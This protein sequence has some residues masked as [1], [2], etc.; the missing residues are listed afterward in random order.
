MSS[1]FSLLELLITLTI[2][3]ILTAIAYP[4]YTQHIIKT[5]R[6]DAKTS[7]YQLATNLEIY[8]AEHNT[9]SG[10]P[11]DNN[12]SSQRFYQLTVLTTD[13]NSYSL[14]ASPVGPQQADKECGSFLLSHTGEKSNSELNQNQHCW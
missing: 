12:L 8:Y 13:E 4:Q 9:Y 3:S 1:A 14:Q 11:F 2:L 6:S 7:L 5:R 10:F